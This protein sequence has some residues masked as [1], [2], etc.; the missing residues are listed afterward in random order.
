MIGHGRIALRI[1]S[2]LCTERLVMAEF[3]IPVKHMS[4]K[5]F[6]GKEVVDRILEAQRF[7]E[8]DQYR[9]TTHNKGIM[10]GIDAVALALGQDW[11]AIEAAAHSYAAL[12]DSR[13]GPL[14]RYRLSKDGEN[15]EG[16][17]EMP[18]SVGTKGGAI[19]TNPSYI[20]T[21]SILGFP[22]SVEL[23]HIMVSVGLA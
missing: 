19:E 12:G 14:T 23:G 4:W 15:F 3:K 20:N 21:H 16:R 9:A 8:L 1:L 17:I 5:S 13:Y 7:A 22:T 18:L 2:N 11:R 10:N 6:P